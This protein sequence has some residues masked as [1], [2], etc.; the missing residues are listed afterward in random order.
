VSHQEYYLLMS[1]FGTRDLDLPAVAMLGLQ[2][3][4]WE[5][6]L[7]QAVL[8]GSP[9]ASAGVVPGDRIRRVAGEPFHSLLQWQ[10]STTVLLTIE[11]AGRQREVSLSAQPVGIQRALLD[12]TRASVRTFACG[13]RRIGYLHLWAGT[14]N[15][16]LEILE[17]TVRAATDNDLDGFVLDLRDGYGGAWWPY[18]DPFYPDRSAYFSATV[19]DDEGGNAP[20]EA[21]P[22]ANPGAYTGP[23]AVL[24]NAGTRSGK[25]SLAWQFRHSGRARL[26]GVTTAGAFNAGMGV[27][28]DRGEGYVLYLSVAEY[29][30]N[31][32]RLEGVGVAPHVVVSRDGRRDTPLLAALAHLGC[33][34]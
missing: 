34:G 26:F 29:I 3:D 2:L 22:A 25:E 12:A 15:G 11:S 23:L 16:F 33:P 19:I 32:Q 31:S 10:H 28:A 4:A 6:G 14:S 18:L 30:L 24:I 9:A 1:L 17:Q 7:V 27:Y 13:Q 20:S 5:P 21:A 8:E